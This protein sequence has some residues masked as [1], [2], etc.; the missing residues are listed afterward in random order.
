MKMK[1]DNGIKR[2]KERNKRKHISDS[3]PSIK[4][5]KTYYIQR[6]KNK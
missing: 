3:I 5:K 4:H 2:K 6:T 1:N